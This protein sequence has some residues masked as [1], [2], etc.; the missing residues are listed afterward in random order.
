MIARTST[1]N[2]FG[3]VSF[4]LAPWSSNVRTAFMRP[5]RTA[6]ISGVIESTT[7]GVFNTPPLLRTK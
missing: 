3:A 1:L 4:A 7:I 6:N 2:P 5:A